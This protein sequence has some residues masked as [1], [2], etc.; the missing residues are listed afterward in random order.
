MASVYAGSSYYF[1]QTPDKL[2]LRNLKTKE[3]CEKKRVRFAHRGGS[4]EHPENTL[5]GF[6]ASV[7]LGAVIETDVR[8][9]KDGHVLVVHDPDLMRLT[10]TPTKV[11]EMTLSEL[12]SRYCE[13]IENEFLHHDYLV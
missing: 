13:R 8:S 11:A 12:P 10:K 9:T 6:K 4:I 2:H 3:L 7:E 5:Q 1:L